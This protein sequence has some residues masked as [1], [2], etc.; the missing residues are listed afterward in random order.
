VPGLTTAAA[1]TDQ[2]SKAIGYGE[3]IVRGQAM[4]G[5]AAARLQ[6][7]LPDPGEHAPRRQL[8]VRRRPALGELPRA[9]RA[10]GSCAR[11]V[12]VRAERALALQAARG[13]RR[14][15][16][17]SQLRGPVRDLLI[18]AGGVLVP[19]T[20]GNPDLRPEV[21]A[22]T[23]VGLDFEFFNK[24]GLNLTYAVNNITDQ[25]LPV[26]LSN[27]SGFGTQWQNAGTLQNSRSRC[28]ST[29]RGSPGRTSPGPR[30]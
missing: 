10:A 2:N 13:L 28:R 19:N 14:D 21:R 22:E 27:A 12:V 5:L 4:M 15:R 9:S 17:A 18:G 3:S 1:V 6:G 29:C 20:L 8:A 16:P 23:E 30:A 24:V 26:P 7:S 11:A 25:I